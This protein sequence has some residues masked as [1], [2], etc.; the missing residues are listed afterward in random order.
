MP[1]RLWRDPAV[2]SY[3]RAVVIAANPAL[4]LIPGELIQV[5]FLD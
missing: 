4:N 5:K 3:G 2:P 1:E